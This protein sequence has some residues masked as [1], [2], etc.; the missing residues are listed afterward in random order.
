MD[1]RGKKRKKIKRERE[2]EDE[3]EL[4]A[5]V[6]TLFPVSGVFGPF[7]FPVYIYMYA[8]RKRTNVFK[9]RIHRRH[10]N[11]HTHTR[12]RIIHTRDNTD[13]PRRR[14]RALLKFSLPTYPVRA[15]PPDLC[16]VRSLA[17]R[18]RPLEPPPVIVSLLPSLY[19]YTHNRRA[20]D[21]LRTD[22]SV[23]FY[24][25]RFRNKRAICRCI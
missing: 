23:C 10:V 2:R 4:S 25:L 18:R 11:T 19:I 8:T 24:F 1:A 3:I 17:L 15:D 12:T 7:V 14:W 13:C 5:C 16:L 21:L 22:I 9:N 6:L 20:Y